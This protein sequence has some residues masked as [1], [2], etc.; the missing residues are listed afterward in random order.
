LDLFLLYL[1][2][3]KNILPVNWN[4][5]RPPRKIVQPQDIW[6]S[7]GQVI[8]NF[9]MWYVLPERGWGLMGEGVETCSSGELGFTKTRYS[10]GSFMRFTDQVT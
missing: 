8:R 6:L 10:L 1:M 3:Y 2:Y 5:E 9:S 7:L 4:M